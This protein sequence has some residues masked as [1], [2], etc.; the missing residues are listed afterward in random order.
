MTTLELKVL[1]RNN[2]FMLTIITL[3]LVSM[4]G[5][6]T[7]FVNHESRISKSESI[8]ITQ[9]IKLDNLLDNSSVQIVARSV[10]KPMVDELRV[11]TKEQLDKKLDKNVGEMIMKSLERIENKLENKK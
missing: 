5:G 4:G 9:N 1:K 10:T 3:L 2:A 7:L 8:D 11:E 6:I